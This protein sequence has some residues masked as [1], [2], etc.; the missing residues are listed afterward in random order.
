MAEFDPSIAA[1]VVAAC[2]AGAGETASALSRSLDA[3]IELTVGEAGSY[4]AAAL[5]DSL[6]GPGLAVLLTVGGQGAVALLAEATGI[7]PGWYRKPDATGTSK[8]ATLAQELGM[9]LLPE[10]FMPNDFRASFV[11]HLGEALTRSGVAPG[12]GL[13]PLSLTA[14]DKQG[15]LYLVWPT[16]TPLELFNVPA[17]VETAPAPPVAV[18]PPLVTPA[19]PPVA[20]PSCVKQAAAPLGYEQLPLYTRS[21]LRIRV[22]V[23]VSLANK[24]QP[25]SKIVELRPGSIIQFNKSCEE[26]L[27]LEVN[28]H[29]VAEGECVKTGDKFGL[30]ITAMTP[31]EERFRTVGR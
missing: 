2:Q 6:D 10:Q 9:L 31:P 13:V 30:R 3:T 16:P 7:L 22:P 17:A 14:G 19:P 25:L 27:E 8:L 24:K 11:P 5:A 26:M 4:D 23:V 20:P 15:M 12:A 29:I 18:V 1:E 28:G 21:L